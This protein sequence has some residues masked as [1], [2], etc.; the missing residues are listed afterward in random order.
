SEY[1]IKSSVLISKDLGFD[2]IIMHNDFENVFYAKYP[3]FSQYLKEIDSDF[4]MTGTGS[5]F[6][7]LSA[8]KNKL[9][10]LTRKINK[11]L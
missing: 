3:E 7:L 9:E 8:D 11:P 6:Y 4:R 1:L 5:C 2:K 10:K